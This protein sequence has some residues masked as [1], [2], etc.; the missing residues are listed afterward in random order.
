[1]MANTNADAGGR[2]GE[3]ERKM[4]GKRAIEEQEERGEERGGYKGYTR[5]HFEGKNVTSESL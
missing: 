5:L 3:Q 2:G 4:R 1:M